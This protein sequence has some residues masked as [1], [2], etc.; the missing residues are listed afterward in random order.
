MINVSINSIHFGHLGHGIVVWT[1]EIEENNNYKK[2]AH[3]NPDRIITWYEQCNGKIINK[4]RLYARTANPT[5]SVT[6]ND[7]FVFNK[8]V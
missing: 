2:L 3:I 4:V 5:I 8:K 7:Q 6:Q 1:T